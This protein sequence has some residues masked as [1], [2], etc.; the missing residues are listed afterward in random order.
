[1]PNLTSAKV[2][3]RWMDPRLCAYEA[4]N[5]AARCLRLLKLLKGA[6]RDALATEDDSVKL[7]R[8]VASGL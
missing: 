7:R 2:I 5:L 1:M 4:A 6:A 3:R 8:S